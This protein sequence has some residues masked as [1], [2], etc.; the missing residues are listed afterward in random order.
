MVRDTRLVRADT[1]RPMTFEILLADRGWERIGL[2]FVENLE[3]LGVVARVRTVDTAQYQ[4]RVEHFDS[5]MVVGVFPQSLSP[6]NEQADYW[7]RAAARTPGS[8]NLTGV[9]DP[10]VDALIA[11]VVAAPDQAALVARVRALDRVL[12]WGQY[13]IPHWHIAAFRVAYWNRFG[14]PRVTPTYAL[15]FDTWWIASPGAVAVR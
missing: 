5:V 10:T 7:S 2:P 9:S 14:R 1:G 4:Y 11:Q 13:V 12:L 3:R 6:G 15:G 8:R